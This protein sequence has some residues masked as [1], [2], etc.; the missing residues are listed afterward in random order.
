MVHPR[1]RHGQ[2]HP[3]RPL[4]ATGVEPPTTQ[5]GRQDVAFRAASLILVFLCA[6]TPE[7]VANRP[8]SKPTS[9]VVSTPFP[10]P[11][12]TDY[13]QVCRLEGS[14]CS[15]PP[16]EQGTCSEALPKTLLRPLRLPTVQSTE[17]CPTTPGHPVDTQ[18]FGGIALGTG[19]VQ[20]L[21][22]AEGDRLHGV[23]HVDSE[24][25][26]WYYF[27]T[28]WFVLPSYAGPVLVR[29]ARIDGPG[30]VAFGEGP[31]VGHLIIPPGPTIN[32]YPDGYRTAPGGTYVQSPGCYAWQIDGVDFSYQIVFKAVRE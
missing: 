24:S 20:P 31:V 14:V 32:E 18:G 25:D 21:I 4:A 23:A 3:R 5:N 26:A 28:L 16:G 30:R 9:P 7:Q 17:P 2:P 15:C 19:Q 8:S 1:N 13:R 12:P 11:T 29:G 6:C 10:L 22:A 27:K